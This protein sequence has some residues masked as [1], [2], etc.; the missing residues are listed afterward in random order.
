MSGASTRGGFD[1]DNRS[2]GPGWHEPPDDRAQEKERRD[3]NGDCHHPTS[4]LLA[5]TSS[6]EL[7]FVVKSHE[8]HNWEPRGTQNCETVSDPPRIIRST[9]MP[10]HGRT[11]QRPSD[12]S[13]RR[14]RMPPPSTRGRVSHV[15][16]RREQRERAAVAGPGNAAHRVHDVGR[17]PRCARPGTHL[18]RRSDV[19]EADLRRLCDDAD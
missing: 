7:T 2:H 3:R 5:R 12:R 19:L 13:R 1:S 8:S 16:R 15:R 17:P 14:R 9:A 18:D 10:H 11:C 4:K 6:I